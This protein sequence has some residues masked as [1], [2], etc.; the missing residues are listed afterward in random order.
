MQ[1]K[2][3]KF[4]IAGVQDGYFKPEEEAALVEKINDSGADILFVAMGAPRQELWLDKH[5]DKLQCPVA[6]GVG[7]SFDVMA[8][9][10]SRAPAWVQKAGLEWLYR[11]LK[12]P[13][14]IGRAMN[15]PRFVFLVR[16][17]AKRQPSSKAD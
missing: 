9:R 2:H 5:R 13:S 1:E 11:L 3:G 12:Q 16:R 14:R 7:G 6:I 15:L 10:V 4:A 8:G 17:V